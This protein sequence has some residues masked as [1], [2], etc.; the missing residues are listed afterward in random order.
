MEWCEICWETPHQADPFFVW[1]DLPGYEGD[2]GDD[3]VVLCNDCYQEEV[4]PSG[5]EIRQSAT[6]ELWVCE[7][8][9]VIDDEHYEEES[10]YAY[11]GECDIDDE[12]YSSLSAAGPSAAARF[13]HTVT[14]WGAGGPSGASHSRNRQRNVE[15]MQRLREKYPG[16]CTH[17]LFYYWVLGHPERAC[18]LVGGEAAGCTQGGH[19]RSHQLPEGLELM[20]LWAFQSQARHLREP[21]PHCPHRRVITRA[22]R[23]SCAR[24]AGVALHRI[25]TPATWFVARNI[26]RMR[27]TA[28]VWRDASAKG[29]AE[30]AGGALATP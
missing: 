4:W 24:H 28:A 26:C 8:G 16:H 11:C 22:Q 7:C 18:T 3:V 30:S 5:M 29:G 25:L 21:G 13:P 1:Y 15:D 23:R 27:I 2:F 9:N 17:H 6:G 14:L 10:G 19:F 20:D 12:N